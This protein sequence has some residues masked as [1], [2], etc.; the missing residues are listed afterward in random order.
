MM[1]EERLFLASLE[2]ISLILFLKNIL[3]KNLIMKILQIHVTKYLIYQI[4][5]I[6]NF[7]LEKIQIYKV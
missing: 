3:K 6:L 7:F 2:E 5:L 1:I 4:S